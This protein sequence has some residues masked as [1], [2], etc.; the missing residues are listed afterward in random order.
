MK[1]PLPLFWPMS[2]L[3]TNADVVNIR[4]KSSIWAGNNSFK[5]VIVFSILSFCSKAPGYL[6]SI[7]P[8]KAFELHEKAWNCFPFC[9]TGTGLKKAPYLSLQL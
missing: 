2:H 9:R 5:E 1:I 7:I 4:T 6:R 8:T 3:R